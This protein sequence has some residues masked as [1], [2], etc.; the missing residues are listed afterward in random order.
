MQ[1]DMNRVGRRLSPQMAIRNNYPICSILTDS[2]CNLTS[3]RSIAL[4][5]NLGHVRASVAQDDLCCF[6]ARFSPD[7]RGR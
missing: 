2:C 1:V 4:G 7:T 6:Q 3:E 5:V